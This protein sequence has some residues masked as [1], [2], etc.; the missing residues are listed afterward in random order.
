M[1]LVGGA[2]KELEEALEEELR[3]TLE[4]R[5][6]HHA[7]KAREGCWGDEPARACEIG[8][9]HARGPLVFGLAGP[10]QAPACRFCPTGIYWLGICPRPRRSA[11][12]IS[13]G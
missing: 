5:C 9:G 1:D 3:R 2:E 11:G 10:A 7:C 12:R 8:H 6:T 4:E 13:A